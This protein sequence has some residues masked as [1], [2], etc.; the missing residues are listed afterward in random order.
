MTTSNLARNIL[1]QPQSLHSVL[2]HQCGDGAAALAQAADLLGSGR[3]VL[4]TGM[5]AS[6]IASIPFEYFL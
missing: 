1:S 2:Q 4:I 5:G 6:L 3:R